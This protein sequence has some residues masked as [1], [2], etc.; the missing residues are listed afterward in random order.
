MEQSFRLFSAAF[1]LLM[2]L[3]ATAEMGP[4]MVEG[5]T[6]EYLSDKFVGWCLTSEDCDQICTAYENY[7]G[8]ECQG[9]ISK[10]VCFKHC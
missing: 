3:L 4:V 2:L 5:R 6:C 9:F 8:G 1:L 10:C 7:D